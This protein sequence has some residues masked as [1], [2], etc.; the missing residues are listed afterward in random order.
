MVNSPV[1]WGNLNRF[2]RIFSA[3]I[4]AS[5]V[6]DDNPSLTGDVAIPGYSGVL[7]GPVVIAFFA[8]SRG[9]G[10]AFG[11]V[12]CLLTLAALSGLIALPD[13]RP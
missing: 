12:A 11:G 6:E 5:K 7:T 8:H 3:L 13:R 1:A 10:V 9:F 4:R 2:S